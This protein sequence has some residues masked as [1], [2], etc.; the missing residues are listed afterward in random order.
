MVA[1]F[2]KLLHI[3]KHFDDVVDVMDTLSQD[4][5]W[6]E[7]HVNDAVQTIKDRT[8]INADVYVHPHGN[9][10][11]IITIGRYNNIDY[12]EVFD[13]PTDDFHELVRQLKERKKYARMGTVDAAPGMRQIIESESSSW[14]Y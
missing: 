4:H 13:V 11:Q 5:R 1:W 6:L 12:I 14:R 2:K 9:P 8:T 3:V 10:N 7:R